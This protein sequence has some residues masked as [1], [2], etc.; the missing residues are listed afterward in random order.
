M[1]FL[2]TNPSEY[3][4]ERWLN[5]FLYSYNYAEKPKIHL[6]LS[7]GL[8]G[9][10][11]QTVL[12]S[13]FLVVLAS[14][15]NQLQLAKEQLQQLFHLH[16]SLHCGAIHA[17]G[18][19]DIRFF[20]RKKDSDEL[21]YL[22]EIEVNK[23]IL[24]DFYTPFAKIQTSHAKYRQLRPLTEKVENLFFEMH[25]AIRDIDGMH[26]DEALDEL[27][28][29]LYTKLFDEET[30]P[31]RAVFKMQREIYGTA[32]ECAATLR[33]LYL[34]ANDYDSRVFS[35]KIPGY[36]RSRGVFDKPIRLSTYALVKIVELL[37]PYNLSAS[38]L[39]VKGRAFQKLYLPA[40]R[41]GMGQYFTPANVVKFMVAA[42][43][44]KHTDLILDPFAG[45][46]HFLT[47][48]LDFVRHNAT[49]IPEKQLL[50]FA[51]HKLH[52]IEKSE[53]MVRIA[54]T[55]MRLHGDGHANVRCTDALLDFKNYQDL[56]EGTFDIVLTNPP[57][58]SILGRETFAHLGN[59]QLASDKKSV[60]LEIVGLER[61]VQ[62]L[63]AGG[64]M[65]IVLPESILVNNSNQAVRTWLLS[66][67]KIIALIGLPI[68]TFSPFGAN[69]KTFLLI[70]QKWDAGEIRKSNYPIFVADSENIGYD[71]SG[72]PQDGAD[73]PLILKELLRFYQQ[74]DIRYAH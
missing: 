59:F 71:A 19:D 2:Q 38:D 60:P 8:I 44:P 46:G 45:S 29:V 4:W 27:C 18:F 7:E 10:A 63:R 26:A 13:P 5:D 36:K 61:S 53:R 32:E 24:S 30:T 49:D 50:E 14:L 47:Q 66:K 55:D 11:L 43:Q 56:N 39:D 58:G 33:Q 69:I 6:E 16:P 74:N 70:G 21:D 34:Q 35:L 20:K 15:P 3:A 65:A 42:L 12:D 73:L 25:S 31:N 37:E 1:D 17:E 51:F 40:L 48:C 28:K 23:N 52:G 54:M 68:E 9:Y 67:L 41:A 57:F 72:K 64:R 62:F 22:G